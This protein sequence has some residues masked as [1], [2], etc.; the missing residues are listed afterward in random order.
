MGL[1]RK[2]V[3]E[4]MSAWD[5]LVRQWNKTDETPEPMPDEFDLDEKINLAEAEVGT[6]I[7]SV[8]KRA[9]RNWR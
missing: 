6:D 4:D 7:V 3:G 5:F 2:Q 1:E 9:R 8:C